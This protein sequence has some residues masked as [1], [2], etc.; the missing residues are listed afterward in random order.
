MQFPAERQQIFLLQAPQVFQRIV[1]PVD[2]VDPQSRHVAADQ[3]I[4]DQAMALG[5]HFRGFRADGRQLV[6]VEEPPVVDLVRGGLPVR[7]PIDLGIEQAVEAVEA[8][9]RAGRAI[10]LRDGLAD[11]S[12]NFRRAL[13]ERGGGP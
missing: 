3:Q 5:K 2:V 13:A 10:E 1:Q 11:V 9:G 12:G 4:E 6:D 7:K 8:V